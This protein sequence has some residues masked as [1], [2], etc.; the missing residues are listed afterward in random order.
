[1]KKNIFLVIGWIS[2][3]LGI[4]GAFLPLLPT[5]PFL[6][7]TAFCF[8]R[9]SEK[10]HKMLLENKFLGKYIKDYQQKKGITLKNKIIVILILTLGMG[11]AFLSVDNLHAKIA[12]TIIFIAVFIHLLKLK[13][14]KSN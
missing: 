5:T 13:T 14:L 7:L 6:L 10:F 4:I 1:M 8:E 11:N 12:I 3:I 2:L 9:S